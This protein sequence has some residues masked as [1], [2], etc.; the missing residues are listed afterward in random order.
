MMFLLLTL[1]RGSELSLATWSEFDLMKREWHIPRQHSKNRVPHVVP[2]TDWAI[3]ELLALKAL[4]RGSRFVLP[5]ETG[6]GPEDPKLLTR[7]VARL[8]S[9]FKALGIHRFTPRDLKRTGR[10]NL[11]RLRVV[12]RVAELVINHVKDKLE[13]TYDVY[14]YLTEKREALELWAGYLAELKRR[15]VC[16]RLRTAMSELPAARLSAQAVKA[17]TAAF[18]IATPVRVRQN[19]SS[20]R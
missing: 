18:A 7:G 20:A 15:P 10:T 5:D 14:E 9:R 13:G 12:R 2:L 11:G 4:S 19:G 3:Q 6:E 17:P 1:Q 16:E 8:Q